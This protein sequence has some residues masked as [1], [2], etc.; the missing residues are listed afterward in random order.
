LRNGSR[1][2]MPINY[3]IEPTFN[4]LYYAGTGL[5]TGAELLQAERAAFQDARRV[6]GMKIIIDVLSA[7]LDLDLQDLKNAVEL[8]KQLT[9]EGHNLEMTAVITNNRF[10]ETLGDAFRL[11]GFELPIKLGVFNTVK[12]A[13]RWL[14]LSEHEEQINKLLEGFKKQHQR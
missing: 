4:L 8:N 7:E 1:K 5:C 14:E 10:F 2:V 12:D 3:I 13:L 6:P 11:L 9:K